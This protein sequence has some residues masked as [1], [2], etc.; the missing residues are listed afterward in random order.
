MKYKKTVLF[1][2]IAVFG[3]FLAAWHMHSAV[4]DARAY[5]AVCVSASGTMS[6]GVDVDDEERIVIQNRSTGKKKEIR[7]EDSLLLANRVDELRWF[8]DDV[9]AAIVHVN[10]DLSC[11][12]IYDT[13]SLEV[14]EEHYGISFQWVTDDYGRFFYILP[15]PHFSEEIGP[16]S[17]M[18]QDEEMIYE[19]D[20]GV[21]LN[22]LS[23]SPDGKQLTVRCYD[24]ERTWGLVIDAESGDVVSKTE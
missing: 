7:V 20:G 24:T 2:A 10:P 22:H 14:L 15:T 17:I 6:A 4:P 3:A 21:K 5:D 12:I 1:A 8:G 13:E 19:T 16:E 9:L 11:L 18:N 23:V